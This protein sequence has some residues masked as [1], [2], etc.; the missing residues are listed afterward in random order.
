MN[1]RKLAAILVADVVNFSLLMGKDEEGTLA[2]VTADRT[3]VIEPAIAGR[4]GRLVKTTGDGLLV[5]FASAVDAVQCA[6]EIQAGISARNQ[7]APERVPMAYRIG[8]NLGDI[9][10]QDGDVFGDGVNVAARLE[11]LAE[12][13]GICVSDMVRQVIRSKMNLPLE[14]LGPQSVKNIEEP[15][16]VFRVETGTKETG[17]ADAPSPTFQE[18]AGVRRDKPSIAVLPFDSYSNDP[19][20]Q[21]FADGMTEDLTTDLSKVSG[22]FV[23]ARNSVQGLKEKLP[24][25]RQVAKALGVRY[26]L[27]GSVRKAGER[28]RIN[29]QLIDAASGGHLWADRYDGTV[30]D[31]F[32]LQ[33]SVGREV[34]AALSVQLSGDER[35]SLEKIHTDNLLAYEL[36]V[37]AKAAPYP[38]IPERIGAAREMFENV[39][40]MAPDFAGGYAGAAAMLAFGALQGHGD[41]SDNLEK[42]EKLARTAIDKD[43]AFAW[44]YTALGLVLVQ[45]GRYEDAL[46]TAKKTLSR[47]PSDADGYAYLGVI[48]ALAGNPAQAVQWV[49]EAIRLNP[50]FFAGPY[51]NILGISHALEGN[52]ESAIEA[53]ET[54]IRQQGPVGPPVFSFLAVSHQ[55]LGHAE[56][57]SKSAADL[58]ERF[59][60]FRCADWNFAAAIRSSDT[61]GRIS[62]LLASAGIA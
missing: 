2:R 29:A 32:E 15:V 53:F 16:R 50:R 18:P 51:W 21:A 47:Q 59:P 39:I 8:V 41:M 60:G 3:D 52:Y 46:V 23:V 57:A 42:A 19:E 49:E 24:E 45:K 10:V 44:S 9:I 26:L 25:L 20:Q 12:P 34:V 58:K 4:L 61:R 13:G 62:G 27:E 14:D 33:D 28:V 40:E 30:H 43:E 6:I 11:G 31:V 55:A 1:Q 37:R 7:K 56:K 36:Y 5:E 38:P 35:E 48:T 17:A 22:M 54:N